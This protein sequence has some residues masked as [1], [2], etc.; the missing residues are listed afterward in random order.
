MTAL[1]SMSQ[2]APA[3][4]YAGLDLSLTSTG[5]A[6]AHAGTVTVARVTSKPTAQTSAAQ[7]GRLDD[8][9]RRITQLIPFSDV[10][11]VAIEGPAFGANDA[12]AHIRG[13]LWWLIRR[14]LFIAGID[15]IIVPPANVKK[16]A[17]G[18]GNAPKDAVLAA[19]VRGFPDV[20]VTGNDEADA[21]WLAAICARHFDDPIDSV[22]TEARLD[23]L[24][25][26]SR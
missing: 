16:Y 20:D 5:I 14:E 1:A 4:I 22:I 10:T 19:A 9:V 2:A 6:I 7:S 25:K 26:V 23:A 17:T 11:R 21:L 13:G 8:L 18:K 3:P 15:T 24:R 12:G